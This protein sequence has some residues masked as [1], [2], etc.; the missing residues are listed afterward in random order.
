MSYYAFWH[1]TLQRITHRNEIILNLTE[2]TNTC[3]ITKF[4]GNVAT[5]IF[6]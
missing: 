1:I 6:S 4:Q 5:G 2:P 3:F